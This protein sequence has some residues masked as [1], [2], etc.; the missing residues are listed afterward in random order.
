LL[1]EYAGHSEA[2]WAVKVAAADCII[3]DPPY[4]IGLDYGE[5]KQADRL[6][7]A[8]YLKWCQQWISGCW[9]C[10]TD[11]ASLWLVINDEY[12]HHFRLIAE[13]VGWQFQNWVIWYESFGVQCTNKFAR[14]HRHLLSFLG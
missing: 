5:G 3:A 1:S 13:Q 7:D 10:S 11:Q 14:C 12:A 4:N 6:S 9:D 2:P 8:A